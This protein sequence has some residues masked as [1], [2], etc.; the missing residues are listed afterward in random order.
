MRILMVFIFFFSYCSAAE[1]TLGERLE[2]QLWEDFKKQNWAAIEKKISPE[3]QSVHADGARDRTQQ[4][5]L[6]KKLDIGKYELAKFT[7][8][9]SET[10][11]IVTY[12][13]AV[14]ENINGAK[15]S[16]TPTPRLSVWEQSGD[17]WYWIAHANLIPL[18]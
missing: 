3:F 8:T 17:K 10:A 7:T 12:Y 5:E 16:N 4:I 2:R 14:T 6:I 11:I 18:K 15:T 9:Q 13:A 1:T